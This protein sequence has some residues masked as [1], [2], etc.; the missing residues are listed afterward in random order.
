MRAEGQGCNGHDEHDLQKS[1]NQL[2]VSR[3][4]H[5]DVVDNGNE[6]Y[7]ST[8]DELPR[9]SQMPA[10]NSEKRKGRKAPHNANDSG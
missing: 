3:T 7:E 10:G 1:E 9:S 6:E 2:K 5:A 4:P 8:G